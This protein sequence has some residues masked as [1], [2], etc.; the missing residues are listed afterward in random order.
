MVTRS[1]EGRTSLATRLAAAGRPRPIFNT[2]GYGAPASVGAS[3]V[4]R[5]EYLP[6]TGSSASTVHTTDGVAVTAVTSM[7]RCSD[8]SRPTGSVAAAGVAVR[9]AE[10]YRVTCLAIVGTSR[11]TSPST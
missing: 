1:V 4:N 2:R 11:C 9:A 3:R 6:D 10:A 8:L 5:L 7:V